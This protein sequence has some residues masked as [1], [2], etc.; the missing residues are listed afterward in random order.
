MLEKR[1]HVLSIGLPV[2]NGEKF[3][4]KAIESILS[5]T[6]TDFELIIS[7]NAS[8]DLTEQI[9]NEYKEKDNRIKYFYQKQYFD[10]VGNYNFVLDK[11]KGK[12]FVW[13]SA[14][15]FW[16]STF[17]EKNINILN[18]DKNIVGSSSDVKMF[19]K[20]NKNLK[21][22]SLDKYGNQE[23]F[24]YVIPI[25]GTYEEKVKTFLEFGWVVN[26]YSIF[27]TEILRK[28]MIKGKP[29]AVADFTIILNVLKYGDLEVIDEFLSHRSTE[30]WTSTESFIELLK[31]E[32][33][34]LMGI[35]FPYAKFT[36]WCLKNLGL[37]I[38]LKNLKWFLVINY[39]SERKIFRELL[40]KLKT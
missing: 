38:F 9:C 37:K 10:W 40:Y 20:M 34:G 29:F 35:I 8:T 33:V 27:R 31:K 18:S 26:M 22:I 17:L 6:F 5:Q 19:G 11:A 23:K 1:N 4:R 25:K 7:N 16:E 3:I 28:S 36:G 13:L 30:G 14:D 2:H 15:D 21:K 12:Y 32:N 24:Q 39:R